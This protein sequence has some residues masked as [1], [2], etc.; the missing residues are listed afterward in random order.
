MVLTPPN[1]SGTSPTGGVF[2]PGGLFP[3]GGTP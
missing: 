2:F 3:G 1:A